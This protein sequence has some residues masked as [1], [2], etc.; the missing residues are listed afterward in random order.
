MQEPKPRR[1]G[2]DYPTQAKV[3]LDQ[4]ILAGSEL[5]LNQANQGLDDFGR[6]VL[7][8]SILLGDGTDQVGLGGGHWF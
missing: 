5:G 8:E 2:P 3:A 7:G 6:L 4:D 1:P